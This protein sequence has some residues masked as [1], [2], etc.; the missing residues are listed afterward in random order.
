MGSTYWL[1]LKPAATIGL[2]VWNE[3][4]GPVG[5]V[6]QTTYTQFG[7]QVTAGFFTLPAFSLTASPSGEV[8]DSGD[9]ILMMLG[10]LVPLAILQRK[11]AR[12]W[13]G[14]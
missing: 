2:D 4:L 8:P 7:T 6:G 13:A 5:G 12:T 10:A 3:A 14:A 11:L 9:T 1:V